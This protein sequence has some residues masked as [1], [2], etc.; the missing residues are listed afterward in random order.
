MQ[1]NSSDILKKKLL[2]TQES[3]RDFQEYSY[4]LGEPSERETFKRFAEECAMQA[5]E[6]Q[7]LLD[8]YENEKH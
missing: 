5:R 8:K 6:L 3:V 7:V 1:L 4:R 2:D